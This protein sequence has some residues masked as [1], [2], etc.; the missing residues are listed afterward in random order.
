M[1]NV[2]IGGMIT[3]LVT[4]I[5]QVFVIPWVQ[6]RT[7]ER[8]RWEKDVIHLMALVN[9]ELTEKL[10]PLQRAMLS[11]INAQNAVEVSGVQDQE[12]VKKSEEAAWDASAAS[13][14][15]V[16][17]V[18]TKITH[19]QRRCALVSPHSA[20]WPQLFNR[21]QAAWNELRAINPFPQS[22]Y[23]SHDAD[24]LAQSLGRLT[25]AHDA[26]S[27]ALRVI[28]EPVRPPKQPSRW[29]GRRAQRQLR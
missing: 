9:E 7:R 29:V 27:E 2:L 4:A 23:S 22:R 10:V 3:L 25:Q 12:L 24:L 1:W 15:D 16:R 26:I 6:H 20:Y 17:A 8:E 14:S 13:Y 19:T 28:T 11:V 21:T 5:V 18:L